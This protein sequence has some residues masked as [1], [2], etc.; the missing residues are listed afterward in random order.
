MRSKLLLYLLVAAFF[1]YFLFGYIQKSEGGGANVYGHSAS[2][3]TDAKAHS[4]DMNGQ[5]I[6][7]LT[8]TP[9][10]KQANVWKRSSLHSEFLELVPNFVAMHHFIQDRIIGETFRKRLLTQ[11]DMAEGAY[12]SGRISQREI[13]EKLDE[14]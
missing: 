14:L 4:I 3:Q 1:A 6:L 11:V 9:E 13:K 12:Q 10:E 2:I 8:A 5:S 7:D